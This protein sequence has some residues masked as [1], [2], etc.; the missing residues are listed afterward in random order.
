[1]VNSIEENYD[2]FKCYIVDHPYGI[3]C[4]DDLSMEI[5][6]DAAKLIAYGFRVV[7]NMVKRHLELIP[8]DRMVCA[9]FHE[10]VHPNGDGHIVVPLRTLK[11][12]KRLK[13]EEIL[14]NEWQSFRK[15]KATTPIQDQQLKYINKYA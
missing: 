4:F 10:I 9:L 6:F 3:A 1:M 2:E 12:V 15:R 13:R 14:G 7:R 8:S 11:Y 5:T